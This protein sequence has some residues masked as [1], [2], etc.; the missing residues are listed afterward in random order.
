MAGLTSLRRATW[1]YGATFSY[2]TAY[3]GSVAWLAV[4]YAG[5]I[6]SEVVP[7][8]SVAFVCLAVLAGS[9]RGK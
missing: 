6:Q 2:F 8:Q 5:N 3:A 4:S 7:L 1:L 9:E